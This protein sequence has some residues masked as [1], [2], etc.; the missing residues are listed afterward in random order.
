MQFLRIS[1]SKSFHGCAAHIWKFRILNKRFLRII[2]SKP[3]RTALT[4]FKPFAEWISDYWASANRPHC[5]QHYSYFIVSYHENAIPEHY[6]I[7]PIAGGYYCYLNV[8][9]SQY[10]IQNNPLIEPLALR[11]RSYLNVL[12]F[13]KRINEH[14]QMEHLAGRHYT[15][16]NVS[17]PEYAIPDHQQFDHLAG[18]YSS[19]FKVLQL[20]NTIPDNPQIDQNAEPHSPYLNFFRFKTQFL[21]ISKSTFLQDGTALLWTFLSLKMPF[22]TTGK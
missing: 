16:L 8:T 9:Q 7:N 15:Y 21:N 17:K 11:H 5:G 3:G 4:I 18:W 13:E 20:E 12:E 22:L 6:Q 19:Y 2:K 10:A 14:Q 1:K